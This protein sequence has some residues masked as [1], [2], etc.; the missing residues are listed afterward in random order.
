VS[1][2]FTA[3]AEFATC[4]QDWNKRQ[5][6]IE[7]PDGRYFFVSAGGGPISEGPSAERVEQYSNAGGPLVIQDNGPQIMG[8]I[9]RIGGGV[10]GEGCNCTVTQ[11]G[12]LALLGLLAGAALSRR[13]RSR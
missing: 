12:S 7:L 6:R 9:D 4:D 13:R 11:P 8:I 2:V 3:K 1:N 10:A 5:V